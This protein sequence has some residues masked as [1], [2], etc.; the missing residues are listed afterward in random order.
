[1]SR[2]GRTCGGDRLLV[3]GGGDERAALAAADRIHSGVNRRQG[4]ASCF[5]RD[6]ACWDRP[7][8]NVDEALGATGGCDG[9]AAAEQ[10]HGHIEIRKRFVLEGSRAF[11]VSV[12]YVLGLSDHAAVIAPTRAQ[13]IVLR[14][15]AEADRA[16][17]AGELDKS[18][19]T[20]P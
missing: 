1:M 20:P 4:D 10:P 11:G 17:R 2:K 13:E 14:F 18:G 5:R 16:I 8:A 9:A 3:D 15:H 6:L 7:A 12:E 19:L